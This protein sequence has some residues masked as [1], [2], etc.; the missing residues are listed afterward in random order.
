MFLRGTSMH[1]T[2]MQRARPVAKRTKIQG[3]ALHRGRRGVTQ[4][5]TPTAVGHDR[6]G[7]APA[8]RA[9]DVVTGM[10]KRTLGSGH[11]YPPNVEAVFDDAA[12]AATQGLARWLAGESRASAGHA[13]WGAASRFAELAT[14]RTMPLNEVAKRC[15]RWRDAVADVLREEVTL[16]HLSRAVLVRNLEMLGRSLDVTLVRMC[17]AFQTESQ[18]SQHELEQQ[19]KTFEFRSTHDNLTGLPNRHL[20]LDRAEQMLAR[21]RRYGADSALLFIDIDAFKD[22]NDTLGHQAGD[23]LLKAVASRF[24]GVLRATDTIGR[25]GGDEFV[26][27]SEGASLADGPELIA[28]R[29][30]DVLA[31]PFGLEGADA[32]PTTVTASIG[33][34]V[35]VRNDAHDLLRDGDIALYAAK[36]AGKNRYSLFEPEMRTAVRSHHDLAMDL[37]AALLGEQFFLVY[38]PIFDL[39][40]MGLVGVEALLRW[41]HPLRGVIGPDEFIPIL[42]ETGMIVEVGRRALLEA[43]R[44]SQSWMDRGRAL[45][46]SVNVSGRQFEG[47]VLVGD[48]R[49]AL[50]LSG[51]D[52]ASLTIEIT[53]TSLMANARLAVLQLKAL[54]ALGVRLAIDDFGTGHSSLATL[55]DLP[56][57]SIKIDGSFV[58]TIA[59]S[60][61]TH[62]MIHLMIQ[63]GNTLELKTIAECIETNQQLTKL[64]AEGCDYGQGYVFSKPLEADD[65]ESF[66]DQSHTTSMP[67]GRVA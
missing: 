63:L 38:Q 15:L 17:E 33:I 61:E 65:M 45:P 56:V 5:S 51:L 6:L 21:A 47:D 3:G 36:A 7:M 62:A 48:V 20:I 37:R 35:G 24:A 67:L 1:R 34:A 10:Q 43:C 2:T 66:F 18:R 28:R 53:E 50:D 29:L 12:N 39:E 41:R 27:L 14:Q 32:T 23:E 57:D 22:V 64:R 9:S 59:T 54:T 13:G 4:V 55:R 44:Q 46:V 16:Q 60:P 42:E 30:L 58:S 25:L 8:A 31:E 26:V 49:R 52:P 40:Q 19:R 11:T